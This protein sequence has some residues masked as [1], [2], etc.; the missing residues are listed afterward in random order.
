MDFEKVYKMLIKEFQ[1]KKVDFALIGGQA[2]FFMK[3]TRATFD[4]DFMVNLNDA[5]KV[6]DIMKSS[7]YE[8]VYRT[9]DVANYVS[10]NQELGQV[11]F[12][13]AHR[14]YSIKMLENAVK[15]KVFDY[16][17]KIIR[18]EDL[19]GLKVQAMVNDNKRW[20]QD[21]ADIEK[22]IDKNYNEINIEK[23]KEY[24][25]LFDIENEFRRI[26]NKFNKNNET[27]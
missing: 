9:D 1:N 25:V 18:A 4:I 12:L 20:Y 7:G 8:I 22:I 16:E 15:K 21:M 6:D 27:N 19:I 2:M 3:V 26:I 5:D 13:F 11:D 24:F 23:V 10:E 17:I 14:K